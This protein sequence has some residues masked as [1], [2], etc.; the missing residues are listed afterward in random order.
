MPKVTK[1][2][3]WNAEKGI[4]MQSSKQVGYFVKDGEVLAHVFNGRLETTHLPIVE[5][6]GKKDKND[7]EIYDGDIVKM[8][9]HDI[10]KYIICQIIW[11]DFDA[12]YEV[13]PTTR[14][15]GYGYALD[16]NEGITVIG[17]IYANPEL[18]NREFYNES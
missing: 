13:L 17:N 4:M 1:V 6:T 7:T 2:R 8:Y 15:I 10:K 5:W 18:L 11:N 9:D 3:A 12:S 14:A 16:V